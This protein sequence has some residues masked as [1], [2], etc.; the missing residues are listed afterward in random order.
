MATPRTLSG[1]LSVDG[2]SQ[3]EVRQVWREGG[4]EGEGGGPGKEREG[5]L[6][7]STTLILVY[8]SL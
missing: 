5:G 1:P 6:G 3:V 8:F 4:K 7:H 2:G